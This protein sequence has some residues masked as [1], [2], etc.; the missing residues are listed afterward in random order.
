VEAR[1]ELLAVGPYLQ[2]GDII[3]AKAILIHNA[4]HTFRHQESINLGHWLSYFDEQDIVGDPWMTVFHCASYRFRVMKG[5]IHLLEKAV[6]A[7][8]SKGL[9]TGSMLAVA[10]LIE[11]C[12][13]AGDPSCAMTRL[14]ELASS[15]LEQAHTFHVPYANALLRIQLGAYHIFCSGELQKARDHLWKANILSTQIKDHDLRVYSL[16]LLCIGSSLGKDKA[17]AREFK[18]LL[19]EQLS[20]GISETMALFGRSGLAVLELNIAQNVQV[21]RWLQEAK[22]LTEL[23]SWSLLRPF[24][25]LTESLLLFYSM[26]FGRAASILRHLVQFAH[27]TNHLFFRNISYRFLAQIAYF[28]NNLAEAG[29]YLLKCEIQDMNKPIGLHQARIVQLQVVLDLREKRFDQVEQALAR[30]QQEFER[31]LS[32]VSVVENYFL[33][34]MLA[35]AR[36]DLSACRKWLDSGFTIAAREELDKFE[37]L[38]PR[39][40]VHASILAVAYV[41][42]GSAAYAEALLTGRFSQVACE[43]FEKFGV[44]GCTRLR[45]RMVQIQKRA[46]LK[47]RPAIAV[48]TLGDFAVLRN[49][50]PIDALQWSGL[51][52][53]LLLKAIIS[54]GCKNVVLEQIMEDIWPDQEP[55]KVMQTFRVT[56]HRLRKTIEPEINKALGSAYIFFKDG[57][58]SLNDQLVEIDT[59]KYRK[60]VEQAQKTANSG[61]ATDALKICRE[62]DALY[63][64]DY[65]PGELYSR[66]ADFERNRLLRL[67]LQ[68]LLLMS[69]ILEAESNFMEAAIVLDK[70]LALDPYNELF[71]R[72]LIKAYVKLGMRAKAVNVFNTCRT[73]LKTELD[74]EPDPETMSVYERYLKISHPARKWTFTGN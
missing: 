40:I 55:Q 14:Y 47:N 32:H 71:Y 18:I 44:K 43:Y 58:V 49:D 54:R 8:K 31:H 56:L 36:R 42:D 60:L 61:Q 46:V 64:G 19:A 20:K 24:V 25:L 30:L 3:N 69:D 65:L 10:L 51:Y 16:T 41:E 11:N 48:R 70:L 66:W 72:R 63:Q 15:L 29:S 17:G 21:N 74:T 13:L 37:V 52:P 45:E 50:S 23:A 73:I 1:K 62:A 68:Q 53:Q 5:R 12:I 33:M 57:M 26:H 67:R 4:E 9:L 27:S 35:Y 22:I 38:S 59:V 39:D 28:E 6:A 2:A 7:F 34:G